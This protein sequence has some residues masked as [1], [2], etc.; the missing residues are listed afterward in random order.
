MLTSQNMWITI[1]KLC[2]TYFSVKYYS[3][4]LFRNEFIFKFSNSAV[5]VKVKKYLFSSFQG[6]MSFA[7]TVPSQNKDI[8]GFYIV[9][10]DHRSKILIEHHV[11]YEVR[12][13]SINE[14]DLCNDDCDNLEICILSKDSFGSI[15]GW[16]DSQCKYVPNLNSIKKKFNY[17]KNQPFVIYSQRAQRTNSAT[18]VVPTCIYLIY[19]VVIYSDFFNIWIIG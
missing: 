13:D 19:F 12:K 7:W 4:Y 18:L 1:W 15:N 17:K 3:K 16:F 2:L 8:A 5:K 6:N 11:S 10:R 9:V 14:N